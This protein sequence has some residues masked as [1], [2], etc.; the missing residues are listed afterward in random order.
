MRS[1]GLFLLKVEVCKCGVICEINS[2][3]KG[4]IGRMI[5]NKFN[6]IMLVVII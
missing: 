1:N 3:K 4:K 6:L 5:K 2:K